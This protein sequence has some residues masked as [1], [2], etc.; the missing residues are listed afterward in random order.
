M[1]PGLSVTDVID[2]DL[3]RAAATAKQF[4]IPNFSDD[5]RQLFG[6][7]DAAIVATPPKFHAE[8]AIACLHQGIDVLCEKPMAISLPEAMEMA[9]IVDETGRHLAVG[10]VRRFQPSSILAKQLTQAQF[11]GKLNRLHVEEGFEF[12][13]PIRSLHM[14][15]KDEAG[16]GVLINNGP[17]LFDL[18][19]WLLGGSLDVSRYWDD[20]RGGVEAN[21]HVEFTLTT[22]QVEIPG[23]ATLSVTRKLNNTLNVYGERGSLEIPT[24]GSGNEL[25]FNQE[26]AAPHSKVLMS[27]AAGPRL[28][29]QDFVDQLSSFVLAIRT[30]E[31]SYASALDAVVVTSI[32]ERSYNIRQPILATFET[33]TIR[34]AIR[35]KIGER[36]LVTGA[37]GFIGC[38]LAETLYDNG[39]K[40]RGLVHRL[41]VPGLARLARL[42]VELVQGDVL[43]FQTVVKAAENCDI[44]VHCVYAGRQTVMGTENVLRAAIKNNVRRV[45]HLSSCAVYGTGYSEELIDE[46]FPF[47]KDRSLNYYNITKIKEEEIIWKYHNKYHVPVVVLRPPCVYGPYGEWWTRQLVQG[48]KVGN[49]VLADSEANIAY[50]DNVIAAIL[51]AIE[52][53][54]ATGEAFIVADDERLTWE[55]LCRFYAAELAGHPEVK[56]VTRSQAKVAKW[57]KRSQDFRDTLLLPARLAR[58]MIASPGIMNELQRVA[59]GRMIIKHL[60][61]VLKKEIVRMF[62]SYS[63]SQSTPEG[64]LY[65]YDP[66]ARFLNSKLKRVLDWKQA[67]TIEQAM[68]LTGQWL[69]YQGLASE[70]K[71]QS[72]VMRE[73]TV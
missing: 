39:Y 56:S 59:F 25:Y 7:V 73:F 6:K 64:N 1:V 63:G 48:I 19:L 45:V 18:I 52:D 50:V 10:M 53:D 29:I 54:R 13:W 40:V 4:H 9:R 67:H 61:D 33:P 42:P 14:F 55:Q 44:I 49:R 71:S 68:T 34:T 65:V 28:Q 37:T 26:A 31:R 11:L 15:R 2:A 8:Q 12:G 58:V 62:A 24:V 41:G 17:H 22:G 20:S 32:L 23:T 30:G 57:T 47:I 69:R 46:S 51:L 66:N 27:I 43:D 21:A 5:Y 3:D 35:N 36:V 72:D 16:G 70:G 60:P 38:R